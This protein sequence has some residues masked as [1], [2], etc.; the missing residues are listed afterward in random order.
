MQT[1]VYTD[2]INI[3]NN[4]TKE[5]WQKRAN[6]INNLQTV[7]LGSDNTGSEQYIRNENE[8]RIVEKIIEKIQNPGI[9][10]IGCGIGRWAENLQNKFEYYVG[11]DFSEGF[12]NYASKKFT[13][14]S[15]VKF[16]NNSILNLDKDIL[17]SRFNLI[18]CTGVLMYINDENISNIFKAFR[19]VSPEYL[20]I[21]ESISLMEGRLTLNK[22]ESKDLKT[23][24][25]AIYRTKQEYEE[26]F[27]TN[28]FNIIKT[29]LLLDNKSGA[30]E[31]TNAQYWILKG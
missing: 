10:D 19:Q 31:E 3:D 23:D 16:Y 14:F 21:Q 25:S 24:Y 12:I 15:N 26:Y 18:I 17:T 6:N 4:S 7:L 29:D 1:R 22:F 5:F 27:K 30:R 8:K 20:Y 11:V 13:N 2:K 28:A 9:L